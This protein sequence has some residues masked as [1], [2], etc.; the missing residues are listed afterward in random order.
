MIRYER[1]GIHILLKVFK[2]RGSVFPYSLCVALPCAALTAAVKFCADEGYLDVLSETDGSSVLTD[3]ACWSSFVFL[4]GF[5]IVFRTS[6]AYARFW[7]GCTSTHQM[8]AEWF[9]ACSALVSFCAHSQADSSL[10]MSFKHKLVRL[11]SMLHASA[12]A[13]LEDLNNKSHIAE[14][15]AFKFELIDAEGIDEESL[16]TIKNSESRVELIFEWIQLLIVENIS[17]GVLNIPAPILSRAFQ[18]IANGMVAFHEAIKISTIPFPFPY[19]QMITC[20]LLV[21]W[22]VTPLFASQVI[23]SPYWAGIVCFF[24]TFAFW[25]LIYIA[26]EI[27]QPFGEDMNDLPIKEMQRDFNRSLLALLDPLAQTPPRYTVNQ[28]ASQKPMLFL[29][30][31]DSAIP[32]P[33]MMGG[34]SMSNCTDPRTADFDESGSSIKS[35]PRVSWSSVAKHRNT[36]DGGAAAATRAQAPPP[37]RSVSES[38]LSL[39]KLRSITAGHERRGSEDREWPTPPTEPHPQ[40]LPSTSRTGHSR[41]RRSE[42]AL[43]ASWSPDRSPRK[44]YPPEASMPTLCLSGE[45]EAASSTSNG[46]TE[47]T[48]CVPPLWSGAPAT[49]ALPSPRACQEAAASTSDNVRAV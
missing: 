32:S 16:E 27:D 11:F 42:A 25:C 31:S 30:Q 19:A 13:E 22:V 26:L 1:G 10:I 44:L 36:H 9:D 3:N 39:A 21:H 34:R 49:A 15:N 48:H 45:S 40:A 2:C 14:V 35:S 12:L 38:I 6:Q 20:M 47:A 8:R 17:S 18:E 24:V 37:T 41:G 4:V 43:A 7:D 46:Q 33:M 23:R 28:G 5:L 29:S